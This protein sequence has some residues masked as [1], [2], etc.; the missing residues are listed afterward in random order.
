MGNV[1][2]P[3]DARYRRIVILTSIYAS[4]VVAAHTI[5]IDFGK[6]E[7]I[8]SG[9]Q[10]YINKKIDNYYG[11][12]EEDLLKLPSPADSLTPKE[13]KPSIFPTITIKTIE[14]P[15]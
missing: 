15:K 13:I 14:K 5:M 9:I 2:N 7:H 1:F 4:S 6:Q 10:R 8:F 12:T 3:G 11:I